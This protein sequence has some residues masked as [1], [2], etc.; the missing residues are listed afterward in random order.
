MREGKGFVVQEL[1]TK[2]GRDE[3]F[4]MFDKA[5]AGADNDEARQDI[6]KAKADFAARALAVGEWLNHWY[7]Q[8]YWEAKEK[9]EGLRRH[10]PKR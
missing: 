5:L 7:R 3:C 2:A 4:A 8:T 6:A 9:V 10:M 1:I